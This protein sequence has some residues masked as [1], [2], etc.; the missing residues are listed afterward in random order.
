M[1]TYLIKFVTKHLL[2]VSIHFW[3][4]SFWGMNELT[5][6]VLFI[7]K[8]YI[9]MIKWSLRLQITVSYIGNASLIRNNK[10]GKVRTT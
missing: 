7:N 10:T 6:Y 4:V 8:S 1:L 3:K 2:I 9:H 5:R